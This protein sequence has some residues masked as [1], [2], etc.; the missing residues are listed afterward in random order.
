M[1]N[2]VDCA[3]SILGTKDATRASA[4]M[5]RRRCILKWILPC[6]GER[7][8]TGGDVAVG[9]PGYTTT[10]M[11]VMQRL[12]HFQAVT[13][14]CGRRSYS[15]V[16]QTSRRES[17]QSARRRLFVPPHLSFQP[18]PHELTR[19]RARSDR[20]QEACL[21][22]HLRTGW[23]EAQTPCANNPDFLGLVH[24]CMHHTLHYTIQSTTSIL[25]PSLVP[26]RSRYHASDHGTFENTALS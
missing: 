20:Y 19:C 24:E 8:D 2:E 10:V 17:R 3:S 16:Y 14:P 22:A 9:R 1:R 15:T 7:L 5:R 23:P 26:W 6:L 11:Q 18:T 13:G 25:F 4:S 21:R 12:F